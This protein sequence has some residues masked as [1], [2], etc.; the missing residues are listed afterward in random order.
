VTLD[1]AGQELITR[2]MLGQ[3]R[4]VAEYTRAMLIN[5]PRQAGKTTLLEQLHT[6]LGGWLRSLD[7]DVERTS[8]SRSRGV[9]HGR[10][11]PD[12]PGRGPAC[13]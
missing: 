5:G 6:E 4:E 10:A 7:V 2:H 13:W 11:A 8:A 12:L 3:L 9:R 1:D